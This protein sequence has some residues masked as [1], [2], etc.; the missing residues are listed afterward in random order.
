MHA[1]RKVKLASPKTLTRKL[2]NENS[3]SPFL[4][5]LMRREVRWFAYTDAQVACWLLVESANKLAKK[6]L[7][8]VQ[9][10]I[11]RC[12]ESRIRETALGGYSR[13]AVLQGCVQAQKSLKRNSEKKM[14]SH[15]HVRKAN[16]KT[17]VSVCFSYI[18]VY[19]YTYTYTFQHNTMH[20]NL[21]LRILYIHN[22]FFWGFTCCKKNI[23]FIRCQYVNDS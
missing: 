13:S 23:F 3:L 1:L 18:C 11:S 16:A 9:S 20:A 6:N 17:G 21:Y 22:Y 8:E 19:I 5:E 4:Q 10:Q 2:N 12:C 15:N 14:S 7:T